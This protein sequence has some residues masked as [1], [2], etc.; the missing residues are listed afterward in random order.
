M[1]DAALEVFELVL[2]IAVLCVLQLIL[3][4]LPTLAAEA[5]PDSGGAEKAEC[6]DEAVE[7]AFDDDDDDFTSAVPLPFVNAAI[8]VFK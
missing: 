4:A 7:E 1:V 2:E 3:L 5:E 6:I 8:S